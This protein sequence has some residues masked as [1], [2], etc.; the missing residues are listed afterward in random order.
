M[1][2]WPLL[3]WIMLVFLLIP[4][5]TEAQVSGQIIFL[6]GNENTDPGINENNPPSTL[7]YG[8][9]YAYAPSDNEVFRLTNWGYNR[10][11]TLSPDGK[12]IAY[13]SVPENIVTLAESDEYFFDYDRDAPSNIWLMDLTTLEATRIADQTGDGQLRSRPVW[14]PE[15]NQVAW[16]ERSAGDALNQKMVVYD[17]ETAESQIWLEGR[18]GGC[19]DGGIIHVQPLSGWGSHI[20]FE[21]WSC[22]ATTPPTVLFYTQSSLDLSVQ[23]NLPDRTVDY[24]RS[25]T[26]AWAKRGG[27]WFYTVE[28]PNSW[29]LIDPQ[30]G[31]QFTLSTPPLLQNLNG[32]GLHLS[33]AG[34]NWSIIQVDRSE[35]QLP[36]SGAEVALSPDG[37]SVAYLD[38]NT[39]YLWQNGISEPLLPAALSDWQILSLDWS[40]MNWVAEGEVSSNLE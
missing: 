40:P 7:G 37:S 23:I 21:H 24:D 33:V 8:D 36:E 25:R 32:E 39:A 17:L 16:R 15:S 19:F 29:L 13:Q 27:E 31:E 20:A 18:G 6:R 12:M 3:S 4:K 11:P 38:S 10:A 5:A 34:G 9:L 1:K 2:H 35:V 28:L 30:T 26:W 14:S 22:K